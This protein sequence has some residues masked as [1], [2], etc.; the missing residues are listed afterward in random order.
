MDT[1]VNKLLRLTESVDTNVNK[2]LRLE[3]TEKLENRNQFQR[4]KSYL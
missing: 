4:G 2:L 3:F 1:N